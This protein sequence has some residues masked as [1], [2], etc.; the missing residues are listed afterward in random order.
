MAF[1]LLAGMIFGAGG[2]LLVP[3]VPDFVVS[4]LTPSFLLLLGEFCTFVILRFFIGTPRGELVEPF[5]LVGCAGAF[6]FPVSFATAMRPDRFKGGGRSSEFCF[7]EMG[8][9][10]RET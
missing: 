8:P 1:L 10:R 2:A 3:A 4:V 7:S 9:K 5:D 6:L